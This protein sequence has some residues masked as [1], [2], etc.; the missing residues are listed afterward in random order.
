MAA[1]LNRQIF[2]SRPL[3]KPTQPL[4]D[5]VSGNLWGEFVRLC[6]SQSSIG[7]VDGRLV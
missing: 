4:V 1:A 6:D 5:A 3:S 2:L 7:P